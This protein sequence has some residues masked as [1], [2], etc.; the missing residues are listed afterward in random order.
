[1]EMPQPEMVKV[2]AIHIHAVR[3]ERVEVAIADLT[4]VHE[5]D[6]QFEGR[7][8]AVQIVF[9]LQ[10]HERVEVANV[11]DGRLADANRADFLGL[12]EADLDAGV[13]QQDRECRR[14]HPSG[15]S[16]PDDDDL[17]DVHVLH[18]FP[19]SLHGLT[20]PRIMFQKC[21]VCLHPCDS[22]LHGRAH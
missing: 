20:G 1:M 7:I 18:V 6:P 5:L 14:S 11:R 2:D 22:A 8:R 16:T 13:P 9:F 21:A 3:A 4:P 19:Q 15:S 12:D 17:F 10:A